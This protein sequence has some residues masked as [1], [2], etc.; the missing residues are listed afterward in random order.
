MT[1]KECDQLSSQ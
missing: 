1:V